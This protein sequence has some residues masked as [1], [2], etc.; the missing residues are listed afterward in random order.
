[1]PVHKAEEIL[2]QRKRNER[3]NVDDDQIG[4]DD[5]EYFGMADDE[6]EILRNKL[7]EEVNDTFEPGSSAVYGP[8]L[9]PPAKIPKPDDEEETFQ[10]GVR[11]LHSVCS[12]LHQ[13]W[14]DDSEYKHFS[15]VH[16]SSS[17]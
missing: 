5:E 16:S 6:N 17:V 7:E 10:D 11:S 13:Q 2:N 15:T 4:E 8:D 9:A 1:M 12:Q 3:E 14:D